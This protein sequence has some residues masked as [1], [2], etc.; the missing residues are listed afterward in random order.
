MANHLALPGP[1]SVVGISQEPPMCVL[2]HLL[3]KLDSSQET[4]GYLDI[5][6]LW[7]SK[8]LYHREGFFEFENEK[9]VISSL[10][11][12]EGPASSLA[13]SILKFL[14]T[15]NEFQLLTLGPI[16][17]LPHNM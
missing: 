14:S 1:E 5:T 15:G 11:P 4:Y 2:S 10:L 6:P 9:Y 7:T 12:G 13:P 17:F 3:A 16:Y 8:E